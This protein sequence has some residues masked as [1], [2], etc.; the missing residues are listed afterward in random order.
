G[1]IVA[2]AVVRLLRRTA[3]YRLA[4]AI[5]VAAFASHFLIVIL[6]FAFLL[7]AGNLRKGTDLGTAPTRSSFAVAPPV[8]MLAFTGLETVANLAAETREPGRTLPRSLFV[9]IGL[10]VVVSFAIGLVGLSAY[11]AHP[12]ATGTWVSDLG[13]RWLN[14]PLVGI[15]VALH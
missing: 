2:V 13:T 1:I 8:A 4:R 11:P 15:V 5:A 12:T 10:T 3:V 6:G 7:S 9:G 14:A